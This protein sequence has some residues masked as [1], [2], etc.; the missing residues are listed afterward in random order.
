MAQSMRDKTP[1]HDDELEQLA[2]GSLLADNEAVSS[3]IQHHLR[4]DD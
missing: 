4:P 3:A 2:L 1:P